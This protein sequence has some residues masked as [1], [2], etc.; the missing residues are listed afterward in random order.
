[1]INYNDEMINRIL[2]KIQLDIPEVGLSNQLKIRD[3]LN[4]ILV[5]YN[6]TTICKELMVSDFD[7]KIS[8][9]ATCLKLENYSQATIKSYVA[10]L[11]KVGQVLN[12]PVATVTTSDIRCILAV[13]KDQVKT[14]TLNIKIYQLKAFF[15]WCFSEG[16]TKSDVMGNIKVAKEEERLK[17]VMTQEQVEILLDSCN[18]IREKLLIS[19]AVDTGSRVSEIAD[20]KISEINFS[21]RSCRI[22]GKGNKQRVVYFSIKTRRLLERYIKTRQDSKDID[23]LLVSDRFPYQRISARGIQAALTRIKTRAGL[24]NVDTIHMHGFRSYL[25]TTAKDKKMELTTIQRILGH[26]SINTTLGYI[27]TN[28]DNVRNEYNMIV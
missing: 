18:D 25:A 16:Y 14:S 2:G 28:D 4:N 9:Y 5:D 15:K 1:M 26:K 7:S 6:V 3:I 19:W 27:K 22:I 8:M 17:E 10:F 21:N 23:A 20:T 11:T 12:K 13:H 24:E